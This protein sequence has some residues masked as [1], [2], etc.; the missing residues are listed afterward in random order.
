VDPKCDGITC[1][2][3]EVCIPT[4][5]ACEP[6]P[7]I[8]TECPTGQTCSIDGD[9]RAVCAEPTVPKHERVTAAGGGCNAGD[10]GAAPWLFGLG[11]VPLFRRRRKAGV[12]S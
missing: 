4:S 1:R 8:T 11:L 6:D 2:T 5:G 3:G 12:R 10:S 7:C 9:G